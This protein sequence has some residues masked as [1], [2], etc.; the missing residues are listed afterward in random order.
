VFNDHFGNAIPKTVNASHSMVI[1]ASEL[2]ASSERIM[3]YLSKQHGVPIQV[4]FVALFKTAFGE[5]LA[6]ASS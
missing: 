5:F 1:L 2:D 3:L 4:L 6:R